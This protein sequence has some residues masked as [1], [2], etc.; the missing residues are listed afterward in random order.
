MKL[1]RAIPRV[2]GAIVVLLMGPLVGILIAFLLAELS[3]PP[4]PNFVSNGGHA[5]PGD[6][7]LIVIYVLISLAASVPLS[8]WGAVVIIFRS[9]NEIGQQTPQAVSDGMS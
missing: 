2:L 6:G 8:I 9:K 5:A 4:D 7:F 3:I 1:V